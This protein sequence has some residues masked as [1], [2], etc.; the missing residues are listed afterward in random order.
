MSSKIHYK[1]DQWEIIWALIDVFK[2]FLTDLGLFPP[3]TDVDALRWKVIN[4]YPSIYLRYSPTWMK[5][6]CKSRTDC[7]KNILYTLTYCRY[8]PL[9]I[10]CN[11]KSKRASLLHSWWWTVEQMES[12]FGLKLLGIKHLCF[13]AFW[14]CPQVNFRTEFPSGW[15]DASHNTTGQSWPSKEE[16]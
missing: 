12:G 3:R 14:Y 5:H 10:T 13:S 7:L 16:K 6:A 2:C 4:H 1:L 15:T 8:K 9:F 11:R